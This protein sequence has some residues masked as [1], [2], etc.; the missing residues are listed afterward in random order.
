MFYFDK[1]LEPLRLA[2]L[3]SA[4]IAAAPESLQNLIK[5][6]HLATR[7]PSSRT[8]KVS[9]PSR[10]ASGDEAWEAG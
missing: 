10:N 6:D 4:C 1:V 8:R 2:H 9:A 3:S 7:G 5:I